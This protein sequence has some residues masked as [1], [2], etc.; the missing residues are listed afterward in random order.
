MTLKVRNRL[1]KFFLTGTLACTAVA[2]TLFIVALVKKAVIPPP[3]LRL[4][5]FLDDIPFTPYRFSATMIAI[6]V[7]LVYVSA[8]T[9]LLIANFEK[10][11]SAEVI[12]F[13]GFLVAC[14]CEGLRLIT[15]LFGLWQT[16]TTFLVFIGRIVF[17]GR[18][19]APVSFV[20]AAIMSDSGQRQDVE[21]NV[22][23]MYAICIVLAVIMPLNT[24]RINSTCA[25]CWGFPRTF[26]IVR[27]L[28]VAAAFLSFHTNGIKH[29]SPEL[30]KIA[31]IYLMLISGYALLVSCDNYLF[32]FA[33]SGLLF[34]GT[35]QF[36]LLIHRMYMWK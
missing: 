36:L 1:L 13:G 14:L 16:F 15:P 25:V 9:T 35:A 21:R 7:I 11:Q 5:P 17:M 12:F 4:P 8:V 2:L 27:I 29:D 33:G 22:T 30:K 3:V 31:F 10:T 28:L 32:L 18:I 24:A 23:L 34:A 20:W 6:I 19:L 26:L